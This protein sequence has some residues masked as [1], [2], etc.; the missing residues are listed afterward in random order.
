MI[1]TKEHGHSVMTLSNVVDDF[2]LAQGNMRQALI[3]AQYRHAR[4]AWKELFRYTLWDVRKAVICVDKNQT[5][6]LPE[7]C[8]RVLNISV[9]DCYGKLHPLGFNS[10]YNTAQIRCMKSNCSCNTCGGSDTLCGVVDDIKAVLE[11]VTIKGVDYTQT[12]LTRYNGS[13]AVQTQTT[14][15][16]WDEATSTV[17]YNVLVETVCNVETTDKGC[18]KVT[19]NNMQ[20][21]RSSCG[22]GA[23]IEQWYNMG[24][25][26]P[27]YNAYKGLIPAPYNYWGEW[28]FN[29]ADNQIIHLFGGTSQHF[30]HNGTEETIWRNSI[31]QVILEYQTNGETPS[32]EILIPE[33]AVMAVQ[34]GMIYMQKAF[35]PRVGEG[36]KIAAKQAFA[37]AAMKVAKWLNPVNMEN[38]AKMQTRQRIW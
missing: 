36:D 32:T 3:T 5:F 10:D 17:V 7:D 38:V 20:L 31:C 28:N 18:I 1:F 12:T 25:Y 8:E 9:V 29:A 24:Y 27:G 15:P 11:T 37:A 16:A 6:T 26:A 14:T 2:C 22:G 30:N 4:W 13:G 33:Y 19:P 21:L 34:V 23:F 35:N